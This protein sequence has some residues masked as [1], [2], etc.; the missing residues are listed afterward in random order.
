MVLVT[1]S[2]ASVCSPMFIWLTIGF[3]F[4]AVELPDERVA[5]GLL[6]TFSPSPVLLAM[7]LYRVGA[8]SQGIA[9]RNV[10]P[11]PR[12]LFPGEL[13]QT[14]YKSIA[15]STGMARKLSGRSFAT[16]S[17]GS[18]TA[19]NRDPI[20]SQ[21]NI[22]MDTDAKRRYEHHHT[23]ERELSRDLREI[24]KDRLE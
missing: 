15:R 22:P 11:Q 17:S 24:W 10:E 1:T 2:L 19:R 13:P 5:K 18:S 21:M 9:I 23:G 20:V 4:L 16:R 8:S 14:L 6:T 7:D 3:P 12:L